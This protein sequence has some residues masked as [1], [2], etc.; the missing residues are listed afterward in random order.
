VI[1]L[2]PPSGDALRLQITVGKTDA[3]D[4]VR[5]VIRRPSDFLG[6]MAEAEGV[7]K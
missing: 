4:K 1:D 5:I 6:S 7:L 2:A 3:G